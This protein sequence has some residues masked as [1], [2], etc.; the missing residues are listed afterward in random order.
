MTGLA[1]ATTVGKCVRLLASPSP[2][3][4]LAAV[5]ALNRTLK[6]AGLDF[7]DL[8]VAA[9]DGLSKTRPPKAGPPS[10]TNL[11]KAVWIRNAKLGSLNASQRDFIVHAIELL[12]YGHQLSE[13]QMRWLNA[14]YLAM[15]G[16]N[17]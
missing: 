9:E 11:A 12:A 13:K 4:R 14:I 10:I 3:E 5:S 7:H 16:E 2:G 1:L 6:R 15:G 8:A 17:D